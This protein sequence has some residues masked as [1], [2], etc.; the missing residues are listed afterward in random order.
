[1][2]ILEWSFKFREQLAMIRFADSIESLSEN[3]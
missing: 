3:R 1:M 2:K